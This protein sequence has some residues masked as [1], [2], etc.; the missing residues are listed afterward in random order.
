MLLRTRARCAC[1]YAL[2]MLLRTLLHELLLM[3]RFG[4]RC[5][6]GKRRRAR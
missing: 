4:E 5:E 6:R 1:L 3:E 2:R